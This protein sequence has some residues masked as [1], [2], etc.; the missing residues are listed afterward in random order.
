M[1]SAA[2]SKYETL[3]WKRKLLLHLTRD[4][5]RFALQ[6]ELDMANERIKVLETELR[7]LREAGGFYPS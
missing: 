4:Y 3:S 6:A 2:Q 7:I 1:T 5:E